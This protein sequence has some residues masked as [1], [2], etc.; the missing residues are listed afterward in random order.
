MRMLVDTNVLLEYFLHREHYQAVDKFFFLCAVRD[1]QTVITSM[2]LRDFG[3]TMYHYLHDENK[4]KESQF[5]VYNM[6]SKV[7]GVSADAAINS[8]FSDAK[9]FEDS[10]QINAAEEAFCLAII[11]FNKKDYLKANIP[12]FT[13]KE[14]CEIWSRNE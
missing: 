2:A 13:P 4:V 10:L 6:V 1:N 9:D 3:Y 12:V 14:I 11:T 5:K 7:V 8:L